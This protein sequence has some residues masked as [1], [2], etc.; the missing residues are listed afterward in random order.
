MIGWVRPPRGTML[1]RRGFAARVKRIPRAG[2]MIF[3]AEKLRRFFQRGASLDPSSTGGASMSRSRRS[4]S[5]SETGADSARV[6]APGVS[7]KCTSAG[8]ASTSASTTSCAARNGMTARAIV[9][10]VPG[11]SQ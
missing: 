6:L 3:F 2:C 8:K 4:T 10:M 5:P 11:L 1:I 9:R 7:C